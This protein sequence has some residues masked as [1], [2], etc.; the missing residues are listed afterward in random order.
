MHQGFATNAM[1]LDRWTS[2]EG[3]CTADDVVVYLRPRRGAADDEI[4]VLQGFPMD[5]VAIGKNM[6]FGQSRE[7]LRIPTKAATDSN[8]IAATVPT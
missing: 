3:C 4:L 1:A 6:V 5:R 8:L 2:P 7:D